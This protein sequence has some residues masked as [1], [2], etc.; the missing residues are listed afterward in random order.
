MNVSRAGGGR[1]G[2]R[3]AASHERPRSAPDKRAWHAFCLELCAVSVLSRQA[4]FGA[5]PNPRLPRGWGLPNLHCQGVDTDQIGRRHCGANWCVGSVCRAGKL[6]RPWPQPLRGSQGWGLRAP[7]SPG[8]AYPGER[9]RL[10]LRG[11][12]FLRSCFSSWRRSPSW[13]VSRDRAVRDRAGDRDDIRRGE[14]RLGV[15]RGGGS[16]E[17]NRCLRETGRD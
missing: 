6:A 8:P 13:S 15:R 17:E 4:G 16:R 12:I 7:S 14:A 2:A 11:P 5:G 3:G 10:A 1:E 9:S